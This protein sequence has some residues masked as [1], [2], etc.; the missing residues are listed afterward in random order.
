MCKFELSTTGYLLYSGSL[1]LFHDIYNTSRDVPDGISSLEIRFE[2]PHCLLMFWRK[3]V[4]CLG[5]ITNLV[6]RLWSCSKSRI[7]YLHFDLKKNYEML[8]LICRWQLK[9]GKKELFIFNLCFIVTT[10]SIQSEGILSLKK[11]ERKVSES[12]FPSFKVSRWF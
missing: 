1:C 8:C 9:I 6:F 3:C 10:I 4:L 7:V 11:R 2:G 12:V 5:H